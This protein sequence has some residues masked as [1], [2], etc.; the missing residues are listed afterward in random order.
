MYHVS[1][2]DEQSILLSKIKLPVIKVLLDRERMVKS[3][4][5]IVMGLFSCAGSRKCR[6][7]GT[8]LL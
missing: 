8:G 1:V 3:A 6:Q 4:I 5:L 2:K 7:H